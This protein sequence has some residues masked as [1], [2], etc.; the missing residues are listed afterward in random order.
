[1]WFLISCSNS[2]YWK[3]KIRQ[4][5]LHMLVVASTTEGQCPI[6]IPPLFLCMPTM[7]SKWFSWVSLVWTWAGQKFKNYIPWDGLS[8]YDWWELVAKSP[9]LLPSHADLRLFSW[10]LIGNSLDNDFRLFSIF[11]L[12][13]LCFWDHLWHKLLAL[14]S[15]SQDLLVQ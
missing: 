5:L 4:F 9:V 8:T 10:G 3:K 14:E 11:L 12:P 13:Y 6:H 2:A 7:T 15:L 1:M